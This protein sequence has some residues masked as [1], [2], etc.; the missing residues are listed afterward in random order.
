[1]VSWIYL[2]VAIGLDIVGAIAMKYSDGCTLPGPT[3]LMVFAFLL[4][5]VAL[6]GAVQTMEMSLAYTLWAGVGTALTV[7][8]CVWLFGES[9]SMLKAASIVLILIGVVGL[10]LAEQ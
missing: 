9:F 8:L 5:P 10:M 4:S 6:A 7:I 1:M 3:L 2:L